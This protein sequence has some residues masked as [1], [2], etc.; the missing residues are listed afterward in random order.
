MKILITGA[1]GFIGYH[2]SKRLCEEGMEVLGIDNLNSYYDIRLKEDRLSILEK[3][4]N[5]SF[6]KID[7]A[8]K[9]HLMEY[10]KKERPDIVINLAAQ[11]G[12]RYS[13]SH[14]DESVR[15]NINGFFNLLECCREYPVKELIYASS[16]SVY[17]NTDKIPFSVDDN[18]DNPVSLYAATKKTNELMA[19]TY[20]HLYNI[21]VTGLR[22]FTVYGPYGRPDMAYFSFS[23]KIMK[24]IPI[25]IFN[26]GDMMRDFTY[27]DDVTES[28]YRLV[29][30]EIINEYR[31]FNIGGEHPV[32]LLYFIETLE[33][34][35]GKE[36]KKVF[37]EMQPGDVKITVADSSDLAAYTGFKPEI[38]IED[39]LSRFVKWFMEYYKYN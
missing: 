13:I 20:H 36:A 23:E 34:N 7:L 27:V 12:V 24:D 31:I 28:V 6:E 29:N 11:P 17:G 35:L 19:Y 3:Y 26:N 38:K 37:K 25:E 8:D 9:A 10:F 4:E 1:A 18:V 2:I 22:F 14:P 15:N 5:F 16:S 21:P 39:G 33:K 30:K 32:N